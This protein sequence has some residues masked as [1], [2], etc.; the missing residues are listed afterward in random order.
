[1][2]AEIYDCRNRLVL[3]RAFN[4]KRTA[5]WT[6]VNDLLTTAAGFLEN[7]RPCSTGGPRGN[8]KKYYFGLHRGSAKVT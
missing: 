8:F 4:P 2:G 6:L 1:M 3:Y 5:R 7:V